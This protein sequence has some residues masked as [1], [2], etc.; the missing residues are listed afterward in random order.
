LSSG[1]FECHAIL[2]F[3]DGAN[4]KTLSEIKKFLGG[5]FLAD[6]L[7][8]EVVPVPTDEAIIQ[9]DNEVTVGPDR[10]VDQSPDADCHIIILILIDP[11]RGSIRA[12]DSVILVDGIPIHALIFDEETKLRK[13]FRIKKFIA[14]FSKK[15]SGYIRHEKN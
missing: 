15:K 8:V 2:F 14:I 10:S 7:V 9:M 6:N 11:N 12:D 1:F 4:L 5:Y 13:R 3:D